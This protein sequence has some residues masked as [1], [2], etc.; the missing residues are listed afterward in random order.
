MGVGVFLGE[1]LARRKS[2]DGH[3]KLVEEIS[4][5]DLED[6]REGSIGPGVGVERLKRVCGGMFRMIP[7]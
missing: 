6:P 2:R 5:Q 3:W 7:S 4:W 1:R